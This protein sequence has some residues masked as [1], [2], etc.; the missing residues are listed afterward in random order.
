MNRNDLM[1]ALSGIDPKYIEEAAFELHGKPV[2]KQDAKV[3]RFRKGL[4]IALPAVAA[5]FVV[6]A[7]A[8]IMPTLR[9]LSKSESA[10]PAMS[11]AAEAPAMDE[12]AGE[13]AMN[14]AAEA[15]AMTE[16][17]EAPAMN[18]TDEAAAMSDAATEA[19]GAA[20]EESSY[21]AE[22]GLISA[23]YEAGILTVECEN[24]L[25][26]DADE[27]EYSVTGTDAD[28]ETVYGSGTLKDIIK[29]RDPL[30]LDLTDLALLNGTYTL[31][32]NGES[33]EFTI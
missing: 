32:I 31:S 10:A 13:P 7:V 14:E 15:P 17:A 20:E 9:N 5:A 22:L 19:A 24:T 30:T 1:D 12:A 3:I 28:K 6:L 2:R 29:G 4:L 27:M 11:E 18:E 33:I 21:Y 25:P 23:T 16:A 26:A 8:I